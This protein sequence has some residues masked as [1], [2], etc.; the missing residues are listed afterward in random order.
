LPE[1]VHVV[2]SCVLKNLLKHRGYFK[3]KRYLL[4]VGQMLNEFRTS[5][6]YYVDTSILTPLR[7]YF[8]NTSS[9]MFY[10]SCYNDGLVPARLRICM[11]A[12]LFL[13]LS[14]VILVMLNKNL[15]NVGK[16]LPNGTAWH[17]RKLQC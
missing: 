15:R 6:C 17:R 14:C 5:G 13:F 1:M 16:Y 9:E 12:I 10:I 8:C 3:G 4:S 2:T 7:L 11:F